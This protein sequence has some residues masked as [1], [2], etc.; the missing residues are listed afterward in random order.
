MFFCWHQNWI[1]WAVS[2]LNSDSASDIGP[3]FFLLPV[4]N[5][6]RHRWEVKSGYL[7]FWSTTQQKKLNN[8]DWGNW[9]WMVNIC[10]YSHGKAHALFAQVWT[11]AHP[12]AQKA[13]GI[14]TAK[15]APGLA[16]E[17]V[18]KGVT[19][20]QPSFLTLDQSEAGQNS[21]TFLV[22]MSLFTVFPIDLPH[23]GACIS[24]YVLG[25]H[26]SRPP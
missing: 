2:L 4:P 17:R 6:F 22:E 11:K 7:Q 19:N 26:A 16:P 15:Q 12:K 20:A 8:V 25:R 23:L 1:P 13:M 24:F 21:T 14:L 10:W 3:G 18:M 9:L 5:I